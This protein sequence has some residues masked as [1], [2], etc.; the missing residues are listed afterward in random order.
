MES[1]CGR[2]LAV[3]DCSTKYHHQILNNNLSQEPDSSLPSP[4]A[5]AEFT[6]PLC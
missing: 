1:K 4:N 6:R 5:Q 3:N 2:D